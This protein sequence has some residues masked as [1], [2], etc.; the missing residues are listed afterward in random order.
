MAGPTTLGYMYVLSPATLAVAA[1]C[2]LDGG[3]ATV[4]LS[5]LQLNV[6]C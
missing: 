1:C 5:Y 2:E 4:V 3:A 6:L